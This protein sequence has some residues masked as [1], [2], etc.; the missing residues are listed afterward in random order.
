MN[1]RDFLKTCLAGVSVAA[2][3]ALAFGKVDFP[4]GEYSGPVL[5]PWQ[6]EFLKA[7]AT[8]QERLLMTGLGCGKTFLQAFEIKCHLTGIYPEWWEGKRFDHPVKVWAVGKQIN[9]TVRELTP[10]IG[11]T[12]VLHKNGISKF[13]RK[14][15]EPIQ[16]QGGAP[17]VICMDDEIDDVGKQLMAYQ[18]GLTRLLTSGGI[19]MIA[20]TPMRGVTPIISRFER[21]DLF[22]MNVG[23]DETPH[24]INE[25]RS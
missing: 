25:P 22:R 12:S 8:N 13:Y 7:G 19:M 16:W 3:P 5:Y 4:S 14:D 21:K 1:R 23:W 17:D 6:C 20:T 2:C 18:E 11:K 10:V 9:E 24:M 15:Y